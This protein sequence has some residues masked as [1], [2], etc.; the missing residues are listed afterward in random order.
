MDAHDIYE[1][2]ITRAAGRA[3]GLEPLAERLQLSAAL[4]QDWLDGHQTPDVPTVLRLL[5][6]A[7]DG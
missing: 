3:G 2:L 6:I 4:L 5:E 7:L 1:R